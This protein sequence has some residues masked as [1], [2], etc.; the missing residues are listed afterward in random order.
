MTLWSV[1]SEHGSLVFLLYNFMNKIHAC[2]HRIIHGC[3]FLWPQKLDKDAFKF[4]KVGSDITLARSTEIYH[5]S[6]KFSPSPNK[7]I[8]RTFSGIRHRL[9]SLFVSIVEFDDLWYDLHILVFVCAPCSLEVSVVQ[10]SQ[11]YGF[12]TR[13]KYLEKRLKLPFWS[14][15]QLISIHCRHKY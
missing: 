14:L 12:L 10:R 6:A 9:L 8:N 13:S 2:K 5:L 15:P 7:L 3:E 4:S 1:R 11:A